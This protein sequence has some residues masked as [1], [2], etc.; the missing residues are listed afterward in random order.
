[1]ATMTQAPPLARLAAV[2]AERARATGRGSPSGADLSWIAARAA[3]QERRAWGTPEGYAAL[4]RGMASGARAPSD[5]TKGGGDVT[6]KK[7]GAGKKKSKGLGA[8]IKAAVGL[9]PKK[10][11]APRRAAGGGR[12]PKTSGT[13]L[14]N[15][16]LAAL[17]ALGDGR[18]A[19]GQELA[20]LGPRRGVIVGG[21]K[22]RRP[23]SKK[24]ERR[25]AKRGLVARMKKAVGLGPKSKPRGAGARGR[26]GKVAGSRALVPV[27]VPTASGNLGLYEA[28][29]NP[30][31]GVY[32][33]DKPE[34][35][36][37]TIAP[38]KKGIGGLVPGGKAGGMT[39]TLTL[40]LS[41][42]GG[43]ALGMYLQMQPTIKVPYLGW[44][45][46]RGWV[47]CL[48]SFAI[49]FGIRNRAPKV[50]RHFVGLGAGIAAGMGAERVAVSRGMVTEST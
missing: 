31:T 38:H 9:G 45:L 4:Q 24:S 36:H 49:A 48:A 47:A 34:G 12:R 6:K 5:D 41:V 8:R 16:D 18:V 10:K 20:R 50:A 7:S 37:H 17:S 35:G 15:V 27:S 44:N 40:G 22:P 2:A 25:A 33:L 29:L 21:G 11:A 1:M 43:G 32:E 28:R 14:S 42:L 23:P 46:R 13:D 19:S 3:P 30:T 26:G 39:S